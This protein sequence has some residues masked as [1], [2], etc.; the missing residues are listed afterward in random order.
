[1]VKT[2]RP[3]S[4][5]PK[6]QRKYIKT[7]PLHKRRMMIS[8]HLSEELRKE[9]G[10]RSFT[11]RAG[12]EVLIMRGKFK[13]KSGKIS[14]VDLKKYKVYIEGITIRRTDGTER[15]AAIHP[16]NLKVR[17]LNLEDKRRSAALKRKT[18][19]VGEKK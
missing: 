18:K 8:S 17:K 16:S 9:Y 6:K 15:Q 14:K 5:K 1:M 10:K 13:G 3:K 19:T 11:V 12:D 2:M 7:A 4:K